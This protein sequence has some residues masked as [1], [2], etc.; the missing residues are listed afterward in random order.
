MPLIL[1]PQILF[2][3]I[4]FGHGSETLNTPPFGY[5]IALP[6]TLLDW[7]L[8]VVSSLFISRPAAITMQMLFKKGDLLAKSVE[9]SYLFA[10]IAIYL[11]ILEILFIEREKQFRDWR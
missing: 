9:W 7:L 8:F 4:A 1:L 2:S 11:L 10:L 6:S 3:R 5:I